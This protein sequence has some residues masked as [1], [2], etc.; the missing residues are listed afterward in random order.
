M[1]TPRRSIITLCVLTLTTA[2]V[3]C[4]AA[5]TPAAPAG[6]STS[7][8]PDTAAACT[9]VIALNAALPPGLDPSGPAA[10]AQ[11][12]KDWAT[13]VQP[14]VTTLA[15]NAPPSLAASIAADQHSIDNARQGTPISASDISLNQAGNTINAWVHQDCGY[16][17]LDIVNDNGTFTGVPGSVTAGPT[18]LKFTNRGEPTA[19]GFVLLVAKIKPGE[20]PSLADLTSGAADIGQVADILSAAQPTGP[21]P[22][23]TTATLTTGRYVLLSPIGTPP[24]HI[25]GTIAAEVSVT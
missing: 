6:T 19:A 16:Q 22:A 15:T 11:E 12:L 5:T 1:P 21:D 20:N 23:Y 25:T 18:V 8:A 24:D 3:A 7:P 17:T 2:A 9:A 10:T 13:T 4:S 14:L